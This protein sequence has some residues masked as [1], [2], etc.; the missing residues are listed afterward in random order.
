MVKGLV[1]IRQTRRQEPGEHEH[2]Q[3]HEQEQ[4]LLLLVLLLSGAPGS[5]RWRVR[6]MFTRVKWVKW[7]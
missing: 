3:E 5:C 2:E 1:K 4:V 6:R 7:G